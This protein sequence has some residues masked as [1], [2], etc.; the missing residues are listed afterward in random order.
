VLQ[1]LADKIS[2]NQVGN[3]LLL[4]EP[5]RLGTWDLLLRW[6]GHPPQRVEPRLGLHLV[7]EAV[8]C[9]CSYR[10]RRTLSQKGFELA[11]GLPFVPNDQALHALLDRHTV[12][13]AQQL[14]VAL[15]NP[16]PHVIL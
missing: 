9:L 8:L 3:W 5:L 4:P 15:G 10:Y 12:G 11:N 14:Q 7:H 1:L 13:E 2:G 16:D 6:S